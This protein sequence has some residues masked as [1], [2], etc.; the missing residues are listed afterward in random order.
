MSPTPTDPASGDIADA[1]A[2]WWLPVLALRPRDTHFVVM[3]EGRLPRA[4][5][6]PFQVAIP[7]ELHHR[8]RRE[9]L[10]SLNQVLVALVRQALAWLDA[11]RLTLHAET[12]PGPAPT[13]PKA[14]HPSSAP[15]TEAQRREDFFLL[16]RLWPHAVLDARPRDDHWVIVQSERQPRV[17][18]QLTQIA[19]P[20]EVHQRLLHDGVGAVSQ[21]VISL[22][23]YALRRLDQDQQT[24]EVRPVHLSTEADRAGSGS[25]VTSMDAATVLGTDPSM[26][27]AQ[28][29][30]ALSAYLPDSHV[31]YEV[32]DARWGGASV[33]AQLDRR[34]AQPDVVDDATRGA[35][36][37]R[38][39]SGA[40]GGTC[41]GSNV[42][43]SMKSI[44]LIFMNK[45]PPTGIRTP[46]ARLLSDPIDL[47]DEDAPDDGERVY[48]PRP[49]AAQ[50][51][52]DP[53][54][55][56]ERA[57]G[58]EWGEKSRVGAPAAKRGLRRQKGQTAGKKSRW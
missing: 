40:P 39:A 55:T 32:A 30:H 58:M 45:D 6:L 35:D 57:D 37:V 38:R 10:G 9:A 3:V 54:L 1:E 20:V 56:P 31:M 53:H 47:V 15:R 21:L 13:S 19:L 14:V 42:T 22:A 18:A 49:G 43:T 8:L 16:D 36:G 33:G 2:S 28:L 46:I 4:G 29:I 52:R 5:H 12:H 44:H 50:K 26:T 51:S 23:R 7:Q 17:D 34:P 25:R 24:L 48:R 41:Q 27:V 11:D